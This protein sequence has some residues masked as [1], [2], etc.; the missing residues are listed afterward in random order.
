MR[1][2]L[3]VPLPLLLAILLP[4]LLLTAEAVEAGPPLRSKR[5]DRA[6]ESVQPAV[7]KIFGAKGFQG[8]YGFMT[9]VLVHESGLLLTRRSVTLE[10]TPMIRCHLHDGR[11]RMGEIVREDR[12]SKM[13]LLRLLGEKG[14]TFPVAKLGSSAAV[15]P[16]QFVL[17][18]GNA[19]RVSLGR[20]RC[21]VNFGMVSA[22]T[23]LAMRQRMFDVEYDGVVILHDAMN[24]P[25]VYGG[26]LVNLKG[27]VIGISG[28]LVESRETNAQVHYA[29]PMDDLKPFIE[30]TLKRPSAP[31]IYD[32][33]KKSGGS[34]DA[35]AAPAWHGITLLKGGINRATPAYVD[36]IAPGSPA[37]KAGVRADD[38]VLK[39]DESRIKSWKSFRR[40]MSTYRA[41]HTVKL[42]VQRGDEI[43]ILVLELTEKPKR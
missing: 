42:T 27:E 17:L 29:I 34:T 4:V 35:P 39:V 8:I 25:G 22:V 10:E 43:L 3:P 36:R 5:V 26:P 37:A 16:G 9:G 33:R 15:R 18:I 14:E 41:G 38:L 30:D 6:V 2:A 20:E 32:T 1:F 11:R 13:I 21:A 40:L 19:Y 7:V 24:N 12:R 31:R 28:T 23:A